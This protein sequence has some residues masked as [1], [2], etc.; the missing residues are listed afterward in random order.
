M[1]RN[2]KT[3]KGLKEWLESCLIGAVIYITPAVP[4]AESTGAS[5]PADDKETDKDKKKKSKG[6]PIGFITLDGAPPAL[7]HHRKSCIGITLLKPYHGQGYGTEAIEWALSFAFNRCNLH[8]VAI[9]AF[10]WNAGAI[11]L[12]ERLG[13][14][15]EARHRDFWW[16]DGRYHD[17]VELAMLE[18]EWRER[19]AE[20]QKAV[21]ADAS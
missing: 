12:Y 13:F 6:T 3:A 9:G 10:A 20:K 11:R 18:H 16:H 14:K 7:V 15:I 2:N 21:V 8:R 17:D 1:P 4:P 5:P 19:C